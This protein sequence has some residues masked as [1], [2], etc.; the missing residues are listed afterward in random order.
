MVDPNK[1]RPKLSRAVSANVSYFSGLFNRQAIF[2]SV[3][4]QLLL[5]VF[6][7]FVFF[8]LKSRVKKIC[9]T[10]F[11]KI[12]AERSTILMEEATATNANIFN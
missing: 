1:T 9:M 3:S 5:M 10:Q 8:C 4:V 11:W 6:P 2:F 7:L 12:I